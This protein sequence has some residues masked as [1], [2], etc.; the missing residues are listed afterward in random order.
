FGRIGRLVLRSS[1]NNPNIQVVALNDPFLDL[2]Y[3]IYLFKYDST[4]GRFKGR[5]EAKDGKMVVNDHEITV[6]AERNPA[7]IKWGEV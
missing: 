3:M 1:L 5:V 7:D 2:Q 4:H 6:F